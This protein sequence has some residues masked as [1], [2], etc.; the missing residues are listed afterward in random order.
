MN[1]NQLPH[2]TIALIGG[3]RMGRALIDGMARAAVIDINRVCVVEPDANSRSWWQQNLPE[4][5]HTESIADAIAQSQVA[6]LAVKPDVVQE[7][8]S[9]AGAGWQGRL[10][11]SVAGSSA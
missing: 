2:P 7:A 9:S 3:G 6:I 4:C 8:A 1:S 10:V 11:I 5:R